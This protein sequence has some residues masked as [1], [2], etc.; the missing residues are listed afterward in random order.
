MKDWYSLVIFGVLAVLLLAADRYYRVG[1]YMREA[2]QDMPAQRCGVDMP[3]CVYPTVCG[4]GIC[5]LP[6]TKV[7][8]ERDP[9][10]V[11]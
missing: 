2:Y 9:L 7:L 8:G 10:P 4:N 3:P 1:G 6:G 11:V 5:I